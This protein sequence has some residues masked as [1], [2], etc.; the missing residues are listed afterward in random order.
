MK[1]EKV[2]AANRIYSRFVNEKSPE[3]SQ[4]F[5]IWLLNLGSNQGPTD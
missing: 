2:N 4:G 3:S 1:A 5:K